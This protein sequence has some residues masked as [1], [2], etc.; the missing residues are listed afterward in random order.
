MKRHEECAAFIMHSVGAAEILT[1]IPQG[2]KFCY[3]VL[4]LAE[5]AEANK[6]KKGLRKHC[7]IHLIFGSEVP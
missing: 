5:Q 3:L 4:P 2:K 7:F 1:P 6:A